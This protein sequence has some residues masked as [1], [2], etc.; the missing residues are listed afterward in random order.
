MLILEN[1][2]NYDK[3]IFGFGNVLHY[4]VESFVGLGDIFSNSVSVQKGVGRRFETFDVYFEHQGEILDH[5]ADISTQLF[6]FLVGKLYFCQVG[7]NAKLFW[8][9]G[10]STMAPALS[11]CQAE[12][13]VGAGP[14]EGAGPAAGIRGWEEGSPGA[15][16]R[17]V[18]GPPLRADRW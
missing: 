3:P 11:L 10:Q 18:A 15:K 12:A 2:R 1:V 4:I 6:L 9:H 17:S 14:V 7:C 8:V 5:L 13:G 16:I